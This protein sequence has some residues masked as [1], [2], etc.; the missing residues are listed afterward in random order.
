[1]KWFNS[2]DS[3]MNFYRG[4]SRDDDVAS[5]LVELTFFRLIDQADTH[6]LRV[7]KTF[8]PIKIMKMDYW[9][10][11]RSYNIFG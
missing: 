3:R 2:L 11:A 4:N 8:S 1:M 9:R 7:C 5:L 6:P 10:L